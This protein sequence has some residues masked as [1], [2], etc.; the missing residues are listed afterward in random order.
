MLVLGRHHIDR[1]QRDLPSERRWLSI[2][3]TELSH[4]NWKRPQDIATHFPRAKQI[5]E[6]TYQFPVG[7]AGPSVHVAICFKSATAIVTEVR[8]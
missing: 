5:T 8:Q 7:D 4:A 2:F 3:M 1:L 6:V